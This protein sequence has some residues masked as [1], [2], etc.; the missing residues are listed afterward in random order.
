L[1]LDVEKNL[2]HRIPEREKYN[3]ISQIERAINS[4]I[5]NIA[6]GS[7]RKTDKDLAHFLNQSLA[8]LY[9]FVAALDLLLD[10]QYIEENEH[11]SFCD[12]AEA[13][14]RQ[15]SAFTHSLKDKSH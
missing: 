11:K 12:K 5:L 9:E 8:S 4:V 13:L 2:I 7:Y 1:R 6:E 3:L 14:A 15:I 10:S